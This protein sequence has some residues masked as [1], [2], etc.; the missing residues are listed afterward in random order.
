MFTD[1]IV[2][3]E[4]GISFDFEIS[5]QVVKNDV[6]VHP[7]IHCWQGN[8]KKSSIASREVGHQNKPN[9]SDSSQSR[10][11]VFKTAQDDPDVINSMRADNEIVRGYYCGNLPRTLDQVCH[12]LCHCNIVSEIINFSFH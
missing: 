1:K 5:K 8:S 7:D 9:T 6:I 4:T 10:T 12:F 11:V 3:P 2:D